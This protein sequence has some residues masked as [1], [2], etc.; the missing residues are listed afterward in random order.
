MTNERETVRLN[1]YIAASGLTSRRG[2]D[3][4]VKQGRV[5]INGNTA[6]SPGIQVTP[7]VDRVEVN[8][9]LVKYHSEEAHIYIAINK[10][11][12]IVT[13]A[14]DPQNRPTVMDLLPPTILKR[15]PFP[16]GRL[17]FFSEG[18]LLLTTDGELCNRMIHPR[19][20]QPKVYDVV[21]NGIVT[22]AMVQRMENGMKLKEGDKLAPVKIKANKS[23][24]NS[25]RVRMVLRQGVNRQIRRMFRDLGLKVLKL[26][27]ISHGT[28]NLGDLPPAKWRKLGTPEVNALKKALEM[29]K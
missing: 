19:W 9:K 7:L 2:A 28:V 21:V 15:R 11:V 6:D 14:N 27:R 23:D 1:K 5:K 17:D 18:L 10:P 20:H 24:K 8:G 29:D 13:T 25:S 4:L 16:I 12:R 3:D 22:P 26:K